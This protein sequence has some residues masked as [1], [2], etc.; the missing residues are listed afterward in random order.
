MI[1]KPKLFEHFVLDFELWNFAAEL[2]QG[3][4]ASSYHFGVFWS[5]LQ[6]W[7][8]RIF[9]HY[10]VDWSIVRVKQFPLFHYVLNELPDLPHCSI[11]PFAPQKEFDDVVDIDSAVDVI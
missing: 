3:F 2:D 8:L 5:K 7:I 4:A 1:S 6:T 9:V 11:E 10:P